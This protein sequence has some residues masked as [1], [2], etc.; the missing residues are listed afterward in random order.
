MDKDKPLES[1]VL[2]GFGIFTLDTDSERLL[3]GTETVKL[4]PKVYQ[5]LVLLVESEGKLVSKD[6]F[7]AKVWPETFVEESSLTYSISQLRKVLAEY[8]ADTKYVETVPR[9][10]F[11]FPAEVKKLAKQNLAVRDGRIFLEREQIEE[12]WIEEIDDSDT[13]IVPIENN[14][15]LPPANRLSRNAY[16]ALA[17]IVLIVL[18]IGAYQLLRT[19]NPENGRVK[20]IAVLPLKSLDENS[21]R[22]LS[23]GLTDA[24]ITQLGKSERLLVRPLNSI[25]SVADADSDPVSIGKQMQVDAVLEWSSQ[26][27]GVRLRIT[28]RL[29]QVS[30]GKQLWSETFEENESD[31]FKIQDAVSIRAANSLV[32]NLTTREAELI[33]ARNTNNNDAYEAYLRGRFHWGRRDLE[34]FTKAQA[35]FE[36]AV[37]LDPKFADAHSGL[38]DVHLGFYDYGY[39]KAD[40]TI[41]KALAAVNRSLLLNSSNPDAYSTL[42]S[43]EFLH[44]RN[45]RAT[46]A[47][48]RKSIELAPNNPTTRLRYGWMMS[49]VGKFEE[50][51]KE[52]EIAEKLDPVSRIGQTNIAYNYLVSKQFDRA[53]AK[54]NEVIKIHP[55]FSLP[56]WYLG[57]LYFEQGKRRESLEQYFKAFELEEGKSELTNR[58]R[59]LRETRSETEALRVWREGLEKRYAEKY[60]PPT[61]IALVAALAKDREKTLYWLKESERVKDPWLLQIKY[62]GEY[63]FLSG[64]KEFDEMMNALRFD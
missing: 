4:A 32:A 20:S 38:A 25:V 45:W 29:L 50:G 53:E 13:G 58:V 24:L 52:L 1:N 35:F 5:C 44:N 36:Q 47:N 34:G 40:E 56:Y 18:S 7:F 31:I 41:P 51:L 55:D 46:E 26:K 33:H 48:F 15:L 6:E 22:S 12:V 59:E 2:Y 16:L 23:L 43:I 39:K 8:D 9:R 57:T 64:D 30:D 49:V 63:R 54:L 19:D 60:F 27:V 21:D 28:A 11:R 42:A 17:V 37:I 61:N 14:R 62:D 10:G 3:A